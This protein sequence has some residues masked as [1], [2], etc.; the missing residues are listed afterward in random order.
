MNQNGLPLPSAPGRKL[1]RNEIKQTI[2]ANMDSPA[3]SK[4][5]VLEPRGGR[6]R[7]LSLDL[8]SL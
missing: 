4:T 5:N 3:G 2:A 7:N 6:K 8:G 1:A